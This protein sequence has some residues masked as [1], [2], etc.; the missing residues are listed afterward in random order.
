MVSG[1]FDF[2]IYGFDGDFRDSYI[3]PRGRFEKIPYG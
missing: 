2:E 3:V 1:G